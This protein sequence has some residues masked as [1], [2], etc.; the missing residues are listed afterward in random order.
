M[1]QPQVQEEY[2]AYISRQVSG[3]A[4]KVQAHAAKYAPQMVP[5]FDAAPQLPLTYP[6]EVREA[7]ATVDG[8][9]SSLED[10]LLLVRK[11]RE[12]LV[13]NG[14]ADSFALGGAFTL[15]VYEF[16]VLLSVLCGNVAQL[17]SIQRLI[18]LYSVASISDT[19][20]ERLV[21]DVALLVG[22]HTGIT[23]ASAH[24]D[25]F[26]HLWHLEPLCAG[27]GGVQK[28]L[29]RCSSTHECAYTAFVHGCHLDG[30]GAGFWADAMYL[31]LVPRLRQAAWYVAQR[32]Y[33]VIPLHPVIGAA[34]SNGTK[35]TLALLCGHIPP[36][37]SRNKDGVQWIERQLY[38][39]PPWSPRQG[40]LAF[41]LLHYNRGTFEDT[42][43]Y[44]QSRLVENAGAWALKIR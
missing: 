34:L 40:F 13:A 16:S 17:T 10:I 24:K 25:L 44:L 41:I 27:R 38:L 39:S 26:L 5:V 12:G 42:V 7:Y 20:H 14:R 28:Y 23:N 29:S 36:A 37:N 30:S 22:H 31:L 35:D 19:E 4:N 32:S 6:S 3:S 18:E 21:T 8:R 1:L 33:M 11:L 15:T 2:R 43:T 9:K